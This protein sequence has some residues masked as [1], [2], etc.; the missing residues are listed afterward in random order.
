M[1]AQSFDDLAEKAKSEVSDVVTAVDTSSNFKLIYND[2]K[3]GIEAAASALKVGAEHVY[4]VLVKQQIVKS[5]THL[6]VILLTILFGYLLYKALMYDKY[7]DDSVKIPIGFFGLCFML[8]MITYCFVGLQDMITG[9]VNPE[10]G[11]MKEIIHMA[12]SESHKNC[13]SCLQ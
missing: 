6:V 1:Y 3:S 12:S 13:Q 2:F 4:I 5:I 9:F 7:E 10:Y 11:A 8:F